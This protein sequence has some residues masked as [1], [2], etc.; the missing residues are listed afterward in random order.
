MKTFLKKLGT[1]LKIVGEVAGVIPLIQPILPASA[2]TAVAVGEDKLQK[3]L[4]VVVT[5]EQAFT[6][7]FGV[8]SKLGSDKLRAAT[9][10]VAQLIQQTE[11]LSGKKP[12]DPAKFED[13]A[14]RLTAALADVLNSFGE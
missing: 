8:D 10:F 3:A 7:A 12:Q 4:S 1:I 2:Q 13:A 5:V 6:S 9:P 14:T 11:L